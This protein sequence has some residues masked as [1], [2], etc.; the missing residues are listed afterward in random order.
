MVL[1]SIPLILMAFVCE[2]PVWGVR[3][4]H[5][6][7][8]FSCLVWTASESYTH[9]YYKL[10]RAVRLQTCDSGPQKQ[11]YVSFFQIWD[12]YS[13]SPKIDKIKIGNL[14]EQNK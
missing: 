13:T 5:I 10:F 12:L 3:D 1:E 8:S 6:S 11:S 14:K 9:L 4:T 7:F 2:N